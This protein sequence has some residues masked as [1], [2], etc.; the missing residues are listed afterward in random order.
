MNNLKKVGLTALAGSLAMMTVAQSELAVTGSGEVTYTTT[1]GVGVTGNPFGVSQTLSFTGTGEMDN[2]F[3]YSFFTGMA[4][5]DM[6]FDSGSFTLDMGDMGAIGI[7]QGVGLYGIGTIALSIPTAY[8]EADHGVGVL[9]DG[10]DNVGDTGVLGYIGTF[11]DVKVNIEYDP[12]LDGAVQQ[13]GGNG[14]VST[15]NNMNYAIT[16]SGIEG[17]DVMFGAS[18]T[19]YAAAGATDDTEQTGTVKYTMGALSAAYQMSSIQSGTASTAGET[20]ESY[21]V[22]FNVN[23][24]LSISMGVNDNTSDTPSGVDVTEESTSLQAAYTMGSASFRMAMNSADNVGGTA[25]VSDDNLELSLK[26]SF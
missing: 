3:A 20:V 9:A 10:L 14:G 4:G 1:D 17:F 23:D 5:Q 26:L 13:A 11:G 24:N 19:N 25:G 16:Y 22:A 15:G 21:G 7:D 2:G 6:T 18:K 8:E 12:S